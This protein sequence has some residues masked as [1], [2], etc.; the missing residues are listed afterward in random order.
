MKGLNMDVIAKRLDVNYGYVRE[1]FS[2][3]GKLH[4]L[5]VK[6][7]EEKMLEAIDEC[8]EILFGNLADASRAL[9][10]EAKQ[11]GMDGNFARKMLLEYTLGKAKEQHIAKVNS[12]TMIDITA[13]MQKAY[14][15]LNE[16][17]TSGAVDGVEGGSDAVVQDG[18]GG[19]DVDVGQAVGTGE[20]SSK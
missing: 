20:V 8:A 9:A 4:D 11:P 14:D 17:T 19:E 13:R 5:W 10:H 16:G 7:R 18:V 6:F 3:G 1:L 15:Q 12:N 2:K